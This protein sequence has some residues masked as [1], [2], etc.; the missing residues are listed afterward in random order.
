MRTRFWSAA[1]S[2]CV[3]LV[4]AACVTTSS[5][6]SNETVDSKVFVTAYTWYDNTPAGSH[7]ISHPVLHGAASGTGTYEDPVTIAVGHRAAT[8]CV[9]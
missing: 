3:V 6:A 8:C 9:S 7:E 2:L 5:Q 1:G 4:A